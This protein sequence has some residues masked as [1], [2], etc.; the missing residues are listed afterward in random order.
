M[1]HVLFIFDVSRSFSVL[2]LVAG[3]DAGKLQDALF[4]TFGPGSIYEDV[5]KQSANPKQGPWTNICLK[6][7]IANR[8]E[9]VSPAGDKN[10]KDPDGLSKAVVLAGLLGGCGQNYDNQVEQ[11]VE[12]CQVRTNAKY[13]WKGAELSH[14]EL[15]IQ[16]KQT[17][18]PN[19]CLL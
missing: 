18:I 2:F 16:Q 5:R 6:I 10:S 9:N 13:L 1:K 15:Y 7:M 11:C 17:N 19:R 8:E 4:K 14:V 3:F 12:T